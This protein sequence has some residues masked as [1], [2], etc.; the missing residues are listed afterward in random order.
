MKK[1]RIKN[2]EVWIKRGNVLMMRV[3]GEVDRD[4]VEELIKATG[5]L[6][7]EETKGKPYIIIDMSGVEKATLK[8]RRLLEE[9]GHLGRFKKVALVYRG[10]P[11]A[12][13]IASFF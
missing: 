3:L 7:D 4:T 9:S 12:R 1:I 5:K 11:V 8:A 13:I 2:S 10:N 6:V